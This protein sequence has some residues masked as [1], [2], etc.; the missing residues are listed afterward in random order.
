MRIGDGGCGPTVNLFPAIHGGTRNADQAPSQSEE[1]Q[2][3]V[4]Y[5]EPYPG[6]YPGPRKEFG[7]RASDTP[8]CLRDA[9]ERHRSLNVSETP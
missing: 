8:Q 6:L 7:G 2:F 1:A 3:S 9:T 4:P 5:P